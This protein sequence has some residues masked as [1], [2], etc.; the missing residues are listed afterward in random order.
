MPGE[1]DI[2]AVTP[3]NSNVNLALRDGCDNVSFAEHKPGKKLSPDK[4]TW[5]VELAAGESCTLDVD[6][7]TSRKNT[8]PKKV[9]WAP[10]ECPAGGVVLNEG[11]EVSDANGDTILID[12]SSLVL[13]CVDPPDDSD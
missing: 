9:N 4:I 8:S 12:D 1:F 13:T 2:T 6:V 10:T 5:D 11:V 7:E 3:D